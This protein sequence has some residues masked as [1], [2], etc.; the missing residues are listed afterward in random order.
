MGY[1]FQY[2]DA[3]LKDRGSFYEDKTISPRLV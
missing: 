3:I 1:I 2:K